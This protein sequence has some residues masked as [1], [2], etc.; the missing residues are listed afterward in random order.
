MNK[1]Q[2]FIGEPI[3]YD[4][5]IEV[6]AKLTEILNKEKI[7]GIFFCNVNINGTQIDVA[8][9]TEKNILVIEAKKYNVPIRGDTNGMWEYYSSGMWHKT[10]NLYFQALNAT[11]KFKDSFSKYFKLNGVYPDGLLV[12][13][14]KLPKNSNPISDLKIK[15]LQDV[16][17]LNT[18]T[19]FRKNNSCRK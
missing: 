12:F 11:F 6:L 4:S 19:S 8:L 17:Q 9:V 16:S 7:D 18:L 2:Y 13:T 15:I 1:I 10:S 3:V 5:E 14:K